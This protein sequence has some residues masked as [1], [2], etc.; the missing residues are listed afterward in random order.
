MTIISCPVADCPWRSA[1][2]DEA[3]ASVIASQLQIHSRACH[4]STPAPTTAVPDHKLKLDPPEIGVGANPEEWSSFTRQ[5]SMYKIGTSIHGSKIPTELFYCASKDLRQDLMRDLRCDVATM[6]EQDLLAAMRRLAVK[7]ESAL[8]HR[9]KLSK[10][11]QAPGTSIRTFLASLRGQAALCN[12]TAKCQEPGCT[13]TFDYSNEFIKDNLIRGLADPEILSDLLGDAKTD[14][15][16]EETVTFI[17]QKEQGKATRSAVGDNVAGANTHTQPDKKFSR[18]KRKPEQPATGK[19]WACEGPSH[20]PR[21]DRNTR[22]QKCPAWSTDCEKCDVRGHFSK[23]C[24][25]CEDCGH[26]GHRNGNSKFC[27]KA[28]QKGNAHQ[29]E[30]STEAF[31]TMDDNLHTQLAAVNSKAFKRNEHPMDHLVYEDK[32]IP[33]PSKPHPT[34]LADLKPLPMDH[35]ELGHP[36]ANTRQ[37]SSLVVPMIA[38]SGCQSSSPWHPR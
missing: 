34:V 30:D 31:R 8:V 17:A 29:T 14:R 38:D 35:S 3:F 16:L 12:F 1:D 6:P 7:E 26:W 27:K 33:R 10:M 36:T 22:A 25:K 32:W 5:W 24:S 28:T 20:G 15:S 9:I 11:T 23:C 4:E 13:H 19:C 21:N 18:G 37:L 2:L